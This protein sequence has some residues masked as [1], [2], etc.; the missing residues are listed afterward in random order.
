MS[1]ANLEV[2]KKGGEP[3]SV[4]FS[5]LDALCEALK[6]RPADLLRW[7]PAEASPDGV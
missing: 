1:P 3:G 2:L 4:R 6:C 5:P 7:E